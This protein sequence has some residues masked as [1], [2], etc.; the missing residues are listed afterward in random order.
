MYYTCR[1]IEYVTLAIYSTNTLSINVPTLRLPRSPPPKVSYIKKGYLVDYET[2]QIAIK[3]AELLDGECK[4]NNDGTYLDGWV[5][6]DK[7]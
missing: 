5:V 6:D 7:I 3:L 2:T 4:R 1:Y